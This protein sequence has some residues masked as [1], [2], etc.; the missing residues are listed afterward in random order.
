MRRNFSLLVAERIRLSRE[1]HDTVLQ[2]LCGIALQCHGAAREMAIA[3]P[4]ARERLTKIGTDVEDRIRD[5][6]DAVDDLRSSRCATDDLVATLRS[7]GKNTLP[8]QSTAVELKTV[9]RHRGCQPEVVRELSRI[10]QEAIANAVRHGGAKHV[11]MEVHFKTA[12]LVFRVVDD[13][14][15]FDPT[16]VSDGP[17]R[18]F[19]LLG[20]RERA[21]GLGATF[22]ISSAP[23]QGATVEAVLRAAYQ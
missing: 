19:G 13:G 20:M 23:G 7:V 17:K 18:H 15:G 11:R 21:A 4:I 2:T 10:A 3:A 5:L 12:A 14:C 6:R 9:G 1:I 22:N 8:F 16:I